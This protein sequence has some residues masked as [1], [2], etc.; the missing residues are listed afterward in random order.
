MEEVYRS[1]DMKKAKYWLTYVAEP[2]DVMC[3][4]PQHP[5]HSKKSTSPEYHLHKVQSGTTA[6]NESDWSKILVEKGWNNKFP[7]EESATGAQA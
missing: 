1:D 2:L 7:L 3:R 4:T 5:K 6:A